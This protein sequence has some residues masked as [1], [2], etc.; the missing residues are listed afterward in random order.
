MTKRMIKM[1]GKLRP[2]PSK[3]RIYGIIRIEKGGKFNEALKNMRDI[4]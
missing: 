3:K 2:P 1:R 4:N